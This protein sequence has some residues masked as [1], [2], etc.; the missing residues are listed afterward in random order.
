MHTFIISL[1]RKYDNLDGKKFKLK[2]YNKKKR[3]FYKLRLTQKWDKHTERPFLSQYS[4][5]LNDI[6]GLHFEKGTIT[7]LV[8]TI[9]QNCLSSAA[10]HIPAQ[11]FNCSS[12][13]LWVWCLKKAFKLSNTFCNLA[14]SL[15]FEHFHFNTVLCCFSGFFSYSFWQS[16]IFH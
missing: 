14:Y 7:F 13:C 15:L 5:Y 6:G 9:I 1:F 16:L 12:L 2:S 10:I 8:L 11:S 4:M 3:H